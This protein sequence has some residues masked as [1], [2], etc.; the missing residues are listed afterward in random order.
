MGVYVSTDNSIWTSA[1]EGISY[2]GVDDIIVCGNNLIAATY[3]GGV[4]LSTNN[5]ATWT[6]INNGLSMSG[7]NA[8]A[9]NIKGTDLYSGTYGGVW[10]RPIS[11]LLILTASPKSLTIDYPEFSTARFNI[12][13]NTSWTVSSSESWLTAGSDSGS[14]NAS[15]ELIAHANPLRD[16]RKATIT[17]SSSGL[18]NQIVSVTQKGKSC[19][20]GSLDIDI[21]PN[22]ATDHITITVGD[23]YNNPAYTIKI[24]NMLGTVVFET[25]IN[26]SQYELNINSWNMKGTYLMQ[27]YNNYSKVIASKTI[28][29]K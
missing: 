2:T 7:L 19:T 8:R 5:A 22:P 21:Y 27:V 12:V 25:R 3:G 6:A 14:G 24:M 13:S 9:L 20:N 28:I 11:D 15:I 1:N 16:S 18:T 29:V 10:K 17:V 26:Q 4:F 23:D